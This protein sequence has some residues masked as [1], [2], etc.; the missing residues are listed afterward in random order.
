MVENITEVK[1]Q[2]FIFVL[3]TIGIEIHISKKIVSKKFLYFDARMRVS[4]IG[5]FA[6]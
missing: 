3:E 1:Y 5:F 2:C 4:F 6:F